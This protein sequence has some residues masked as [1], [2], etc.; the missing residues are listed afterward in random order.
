M[1][2]RTYL[3]FHIVVELYLFQLL[4]FLFLSNLM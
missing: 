2:L 1:I 3:I 4:Q